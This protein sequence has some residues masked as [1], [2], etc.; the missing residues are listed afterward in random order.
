METKT[1]F[2]YSKYPQPCWNSKEQKLVCIDASWRCFDLLVCIL[3]QREVE[4]FFKQSY[5]K[6]YGSEFVDLLIWEYWNAL[7]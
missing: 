2:I 3:N 7:K 4:N 6:E 5:L 1:W